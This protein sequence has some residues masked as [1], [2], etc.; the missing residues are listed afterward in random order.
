MNLYILLGKCYN[1]LT[2]TI[3]NEGQYFFYKC[4]LKI[5][6]LQ[7]NALTLHPQI[8]LVLNLHKLKRKIIHLVPSGHGMV[9]IMVHCKKYLKELFITDL[10][11][12]N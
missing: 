1:I 4:R 8:L 12:T 3:Q 5:S 6:I 2:I 7:Y 9:P 11:H 10:T